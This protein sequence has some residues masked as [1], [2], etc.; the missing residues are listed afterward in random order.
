MDSR[1][2]AVGIIRI[3]E[4]RY[5]GDRIGPGDFACKIDKHGAQ[6]VAIPEQTCRAGT[7][8]QQ[9]SE[10]VLV[11]FLDIARRA[12]ENE[13]VAAVVR[14]LPAPRG[15]MVERDGSYRDL[16]LAVRTDRPVPVQQPLACLVICVAARG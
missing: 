12:G 7:P 3:C 15:H 2:V 13:V 10:D 16:P 14:G 11:G 1:S 9:K 6:V 8:R 4:P 5:S